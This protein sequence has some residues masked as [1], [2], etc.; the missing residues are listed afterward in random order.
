MLT[1]ILK[2]DSMASVVI[3]ATVCGHS[4]TQGSTKFSSQKSTERSFR[5]WICKYWGCGIWNTRKTEVKMRW[6]PLRRTQYPNLY[7]STSKTILASSFPLLSSPVLLH[8][9]YQ[10]SVPHPLLVSKSICKT[11]STRQELCELC[12]RASV[13][14]WYQI[15]SIHAWL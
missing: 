1:E 3:P 4:R 14:L 10:V 11:S 13:V 6:V 9:F 5:I 7:R 2:S 15:C 12:L 8:S